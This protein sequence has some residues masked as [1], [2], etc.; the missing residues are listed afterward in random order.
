MKVVVPVSGGIDST[1]LL[2]LGLSEGHEVYPLFLDLGQRARRWE[3]SS[4]RQI[5]R[6]YRIGIKELRFR[7]FGRMVG[8]PRLQPKT[9]KEAFV[10]DRDTLVASVAT[11][12]AMT[13]GA[14]QVW[15]GTVGTDAYGNTDAD[16]L[17]ALGDAVRIGN[18]GYN[19]PRHLAPFLW[20]QK[21]DVIRAGQ[22]LASPFHLTWTCWDNR[23]PV[24][25]ACPKCRS[26][27]TAFQ[28][29]GAEDPVAAGKT[30]PNVT[31]GY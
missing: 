17:L 31:W 14:E 2:S 16:Y 19:P 1:V 18:N 9:Y 26:R 10:P 30:S 5:A 29:A 28:L 23:R 20:W 8:L 25:G 11:A 21:P 22:K 15:H 24:C 4:V 12:Y 27:A 3:R 13:V 6:W 7:D